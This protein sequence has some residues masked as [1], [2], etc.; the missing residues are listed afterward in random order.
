MVKDLCVILTLILFSFQGVGQTV[1]VSMANLTGEKEFINKTPIILNDGSVVVDGSEFSYQVTTEGE[2]VEKFKNPMTSNDRDGFNE[3][4]HGYNSSYDIRYALTGD[5][6]YFIRNYSNPGKIMTYVTIPPVRGLQT[7]DKISK[8]KSESLFYKQGVQ[9]E[10]IHFVNEHQ[11]WVYNTFCS[12]SD[13]SHGRVKHDRHK[14]YTFMRVMK[15]DLD[16]RTCETSYTMVDVVNESRKQYSRVEL[17]IAG[18]LDN[19]LRVGVLKKKITGIKPVYMNQVYSFDGQCVFYDYDYEKNQLDSLTAF[20]FYGEGNIGSSVAKVTVNSLEYTWL[21]R[22]PEKKLFYYS[23]HGKKYVLG[24]YN[25]MDSLSFHFPSNIYQVIEPYIAPIVIYE[26]TEGDYYACLEGAYTEQGMEEKIPAYLLLNP[27]GD[28]DLLDRYSGTWEY[29]DEDLQK[30]VN[31]IMKYPDKADLWSTIA[32]PYFYGDG[33]LF[34]GQKEN[35]L[36]RIGADTFVRVQMKMRLNS[37]SK[38][39][40]VILEITVFDL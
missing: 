26:D 8:R 37:Q 21:E 27:D 5:Y 30:N 34:A 2:I 33:I 22:V 1:T 35:L 32:N 20:S 29:W 13:E 14:F 16:D 17:Q 12:Y 4:S 10:Y 6:F 25:D 11:V 3:Q 18:M 36:A 15:I 39:K 31:L 40:D 23:Y 38:V 19:K 9:S 7:T 28:L 24:K